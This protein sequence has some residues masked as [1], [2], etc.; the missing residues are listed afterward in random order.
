MFQQVF[1][2]SDNHLTSQSCSFFR[3]S[4]WPT[5]DPRAHV[6]RETLHC[7]SD[8]NSVL[9]DIHQLHHEAAVRTGCCWSEFLR[10]LHLRFSFFI[11]RD[12]W[13]I[14]AF[15]HQPAPWSSFFVSTSFVSASEAISSYCTSILVVRFKTFNSFASSVENAMYPVCFTSDRFFKTFPQICNCFRRATTQT[16]FERH[17]SPFNVSTHFSVRGLEPLSSHVFPRVLQFLLVV[18]H[19]TA[20]GSIH[21]PLIPPCSFNLCGTRTFH[22]ALDPQSAALLTLMAPSR[23]ICL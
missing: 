10:A 23:I 11:S 6:S 2:S 3:P 7:F 22:L 14:D 21:V 20:S 19:P 18:C 1:A 13:R 8:V 12:T 5:R 16:N 9:S 4:L 15:L 17:T